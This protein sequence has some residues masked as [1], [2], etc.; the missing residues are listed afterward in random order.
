MCCCRYGYDEEGYDKEGYDRD[1]YDQDGYGESTLAWWGHC[2]VSGTTHA[3][4]IGCTPLLGVASCG[5]APVGSAA[6]AMKLCSAW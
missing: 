2:Y 1:G 4:A 6:V 5:L 3:Q